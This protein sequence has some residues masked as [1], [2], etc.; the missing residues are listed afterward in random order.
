MADGRRVFWVLAAVLV[1]GMNLGSAQEAEVSLRHLAEQNGIHIG[2]AVYAS[3]LD[4]PAHQ[5][6]LSQ[7]F[8]ML[9]PEHEAKACMVQPAQAQF[10]F[11]N[12]D[13]LVAFAEEHDMVVHGHTLL[14][15]QCMPEWLASGQFSR[16]EAIQLL[17]DHIMTVVG[18]YK[19][20]I[21]IWDVVNEAIADG[22]TG[23]RD[24]PWRQ[25]IGDDYVEL[26]FRFAHEADPEARLFYNDYGAEG[27]N[28][29]SDAVYAMLQDFIERG[30]PVHGVGLQGHFRLD[31]ID[32][33][34]IAANMQR[35][36]E[37]GLEVQLTEIDVWFQG[38]ASD[39]IYR[40]QAVDYHRVMETCLDSEYC[41]AFIVWGVTD[42]FSW[43]RDP[44]FS[45]NPDVEPLLFDADYQPKLAYHALLDLLARRAGETPILSDEERDA[46]LQP[47]S[48]AAELPEPTRSD[49]AQLAP[50]SVDGVA[51]Y[52][53]F[54]V[55][56]TL[57]GETDD[58]EN[59]PRVTIDSG[60]LLPSDHDSTMTFA[61]AA[62]QTNLYFMADVQDSS[63]IYGLNEP[64]S[65][66]Y[67]EDSVEFYINASG[68][69]TATAYQSAITQIGI[70]AANI[71]APDEPIIGGYNSGNV[72]VLVSAVETDTGYRIE[73]AVP[74]E[75][76]VWSI[77][78]EHLGVLGFQAHLNG[79]SSTERDTKLIWSLYDI[80]DQSWTN[81]SLFGQ[82]VFWDVTQ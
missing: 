45:S 69:L 2:A 22:G 30:V 6:V 13:T 11:R 35:L 53:P 40:R 23:L 79:A 16:D 19:G 73:A 15:H 58:W 24:T 37:L 3:H 80:Q 4:D 14:W 38:Q 74:L 81:P 66:W 60:P 77:Q 31:S 1:F 5:Q 65:G 26:A 57:D 12:V 42:K 59:V 17:R 32:A 27:M 78:P 82:L 21:P 64:A 62:D 50:D 7:Q 71:T 48:S 51:Y 67:Q 52:A 29:K 54:P 41:T 20:R 47:Q 33:E 72:P 25:M 75:T 70:L 10:D 55:E 76:D 8:N 34:A 44:Q 43:L 28:A 61:V 49:P 63:L 39:E 18:R 56:I 46:L 9:T 36:G 68:N